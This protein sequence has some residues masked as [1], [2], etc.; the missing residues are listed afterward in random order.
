MDPQEFAK[1]LVEYL[2]RMLILKFN[3][4]IQEAIAAGF[5]KEQREKLGEQAKNVEGKFL[6]TALKLFME[7]E[8]DMRYASIVQLPLELAI[9]ESTREE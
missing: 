7:A 6:T 1:N 4:E 5:T 9:V 3:S 2:R 8:R